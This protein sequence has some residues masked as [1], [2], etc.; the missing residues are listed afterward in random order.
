MERPLFELRNLQKKHQCPVVIAGDLFDRHNPTPELLSFCLRNLPR[1][2]YAIPGQHDLRHHSYK[3]IKCSGFWTLIE[4]GRIK[5]LEPGEPQE[6]G[7]GIRLWGF[8]FGFPVQPLKKPHDLLLEV[9][10]VHD[11]F[12]TEK[13]QGTFYKGAPWDKEIFQRRRKLTGYDVV[14]AGDNHL[15]FHIRG[16]GGGFPTVWNCG[17]LV[18][19]KMDERKYEPC[20]GLIMSDGTVKRHRLDCSK[21]VFLDPE[22]IKMP[23]ISGEGFEQFVESLSTLGNSAIDFQ[24]AVRQALGGSEVSPEIKALII[25]IL[26]NAKDG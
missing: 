5:L 6:T 23:D 18:R 12:W 14:V 3:D 24:E 15:H 26:E 11:Y 8:P 4:A 10:I 19:R 17:C 1:D 25:A 16:S 9:A 2:L 21:D 7:T 22:K 13:Q 20:I